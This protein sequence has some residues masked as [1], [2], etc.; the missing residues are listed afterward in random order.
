MPEIY[1]TRGKTYFFRVQGGDNEDGV[2]SYHPL[3]ITADDQ[4]GYMLKPQ[5]ERKNEE[6][7]A[8]VDSN[9]DRRPTG[10]G[11]LC[12]FVPKGTDKIERS[13]YIYCKF[14]VIIFKYIFFLSSEKPLLSLYAFLE[15]LR[16]YYPEIIF[17]CFLILNRN[18]GSLYIWHVRK[19]GSRSTDG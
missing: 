1:V 10:F 7:Y 13:N 11:P 14:T 12:E 17:R 16:D 19:V 3:Y 9:F 6:I 4:G 2:K 18:T 5:Y 8:G 15:R